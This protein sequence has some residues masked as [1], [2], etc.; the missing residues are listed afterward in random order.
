MPHGINIHLDWCGGGAAAAHGA[1]YVVDLMFH[2]QWL[3][4]APSPSTSGSDT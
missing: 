4:G 1:L 2:K 3:H